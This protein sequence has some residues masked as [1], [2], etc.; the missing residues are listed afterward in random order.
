MLNLDDGW[1]LDFQ[2]SF[3]A[4]MTPAQAIEEAIDGYDPTPDTPH[5]FSTDLKIAGARLRCCTLPSIGTTPM[6]ANAAQK[7]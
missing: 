1:T 3:L 4:G 2:E 6:N 7:L 5:D